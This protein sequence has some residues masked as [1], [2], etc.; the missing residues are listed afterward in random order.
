VKDVFAQFQRQLLSSEFGELRN[1]QKAEWMAKVSAYAYHDE[2]KQ[3][4]S[5]IWKPT[6]ERLLKKARLVA[7]GKRVEGRTKNQQ[8]QFGG[9]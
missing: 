4:S 2:R 8:S 5:Q 1:R 3:I 9:E 6:A 7:A